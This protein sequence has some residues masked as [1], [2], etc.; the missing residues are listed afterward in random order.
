[1]TFEDLVLRSINGSEDDL[2]PAIQLF[3]E[4]GKQPAGEKNAIE[5]FVQSLNLRIY[6]LEPL[7]ELF[8]AGHDIRTLLEENLRALGLVLHYV[9]HASPRA[10]DKAAFNPFQTSANAFF[11]LIKKWGWR[12]S[13][14]VTPEDRHIIVE[15]LEQTA[16]EHI[17]LLVQHVELFD[18]LEKGYR[19]RAYGRF[20][21]VP[22]R[23]GAIPLQVEDIIDPTKDFSFSEVPE[24]P[25]FR[26]WN[27]H[28][29]AGWVQ[30]ERTNILYGD[31]ISALIPTP[32]LAEKALG[33]Y[34]ERYLGS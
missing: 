11:Q 22:D 30:R 2:L 25:R 26:S 21:L 29:L 10:V 3:P 13:G 14:A 12:V 16:G 32:C 19:P 34:L 23:R 31:K 28:D 6:P 1:M 33:F 24:A 9:E 27:R 7:T 4:F 5:Q 8:E 17:G 20:I 18:P 15:S